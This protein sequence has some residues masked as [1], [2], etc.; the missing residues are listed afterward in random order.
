MPP[1]SPLGNSIPLVPIHP[2]PVVTSTFCI[3]MV[4]FCFWETIIEGK[5]TTYLA[6]RAGIRSNLKAEL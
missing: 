1:P 3:G 4:P 2:L 6:E 5:R